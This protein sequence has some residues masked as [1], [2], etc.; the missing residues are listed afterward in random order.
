[1]TFKC[2]YSLMFLA[3]SAAEDKSA[4]AVVKLRGSG[5]VEEG[6]RAGKRAK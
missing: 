2:N 3:V 1:M 6:R 4:V 5:V